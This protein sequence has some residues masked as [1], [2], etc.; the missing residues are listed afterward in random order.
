MISF[1]IQETSYMKWKANIALWRVSMKRNNENE[2]YTLHF[3]FSY[4][5][6]TYL[7]FMDTCNG[8]QYQKNVSTYGETRNMIHDYSSRTIYLSIYIYI[9][10]IS[11]NKFESN[12]I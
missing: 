6:S 1:C 8:K 10:I 2:I 5:Y 7:I 9:L 11:L 3:M 12:R 4:K